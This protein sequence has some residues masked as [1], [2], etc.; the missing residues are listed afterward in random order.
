M[1]KHIIQSI[2]MVNVSYLVFSLIREN[3][4]NK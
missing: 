4:L 3:L 2:L 1:I